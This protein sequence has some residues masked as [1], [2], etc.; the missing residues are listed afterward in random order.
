MHELGHLAHD[1]AGYRQVRG[2]PEVGHAKL[3]GAR[4]HDLDPYHVR[5]SMT[6]NIPKTP[7]GTTADLIELVDV[8]PDESGGW[9]GQ[10]RPGGHR[11]I[12]EGSQLLGQAIVAGMRFTGGRRVVHASL[13]LP[14]PADN[15]EPVPIMIEEIAGGRSFSTLGIRAL[16]HGRTCAAGTML[17]DA[18]AGDLIRHSEDAPEIGGPDAATPYD[19]AVTGR[20]LRVVGNAYTF[21]PDA[22]V[23][24]PR[25]DVWL[26]MHDIPDDRALHAGLLGHFTGHMSIAAA[27][28]PHAGIGQA[29]AHVSISTAINAITI[30]LHDDVDIG[31]WL[32]YRHHSTFAG[33]GMTHSECRVHREDGGLVASFTVEAMVRAFVDPSRADARTGL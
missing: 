23:G 10:A 31:E 1:T 26:R 28:R 19:M 27:L 18:T 16:Q 24:P 4:N 11:G 7:W 20:E 2:S 15:A 17:L 32:L 5:Y 3:Y 9:V 8:Q 33:N 25:L 30:S 21:D 12:V 14:R 13:A 29:Q 22:P 6:E